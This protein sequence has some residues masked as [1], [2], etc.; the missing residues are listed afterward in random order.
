VEEKP[1][2]VQQRP[3]DGTRVWIELRRHAQYSDARWT[4]VTLV[5]DVTERKEAEIRI[6]HLNRVHAM[7]SGINTLIVRVRNR[8]ELFDEACRIATDEGGFRMIW[9]GLVDR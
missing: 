1:S 9:I 6:T 2:E 8:T 3:R 5:R 4:I 7:L